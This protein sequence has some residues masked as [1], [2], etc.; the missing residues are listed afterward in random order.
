MEQETFDT[1][2]RDVLLKGTSCAILPSKKRVIFPLY[3]TPSLIL[4]HEEF[5]YLKKT[6]ILAANINSKIVGLNSTITVKEFSISPILKSDA[7][8]VNI[9][10][11]SLLFLL[12][13]AVDNIIKEKH[14]FTVEYQ[15]GFGV[16][17]SVS[18]V[19]LN[20]DLVEKISIEMG[21]L[22]DRDL[23]IYKEFLSHAQA[24]H[25]FVNNNREYSVAIIKSRN[26]EEVRVSSCQSHMDLYYTTLVP[27]TGILVKTFKLVFS[28]GG[29]YLTWPSDWNK[30]HQ[31]FGTTALAEMYEEMN[32]LGRKLGSS[33]TGQI[34]H[35]ILQNKGRKM[36][37]FIG[38]CA[39]RFNQKI[40]NVFDK[41]SSKREKN[42][43]LQLILIAGPSSSGK[44]TFA[45]T[46]CL[47]LET[48]GL[49]PV[50]ISVDD[51]YKP[52]DECPVDEFGNKDYEDIDA[53]RIDLLNKNL[54]D[55]MDGKEIESPIFDFI[56]GLPK[57]TGIKLRMEKDS[58]LVLEGIHCLNEE[59]AKTVPNENKFR[60]FLSAFSQLNIDEKQYVSNST[61]RL[62]RRLVR[63][64]K[65]RG[66]S[67]S[68][69]LKMW[70]NVRKA[71]HNF[72]FPHMDKSDVIFN[73][74]LDYEFNV[75]KVFVVPLLKGVEVEDPSY[76]KAR[77]LLN[78]LDQF[79]T[80]PDEFIPRESLLREFIG[81]S[82]FE[83]E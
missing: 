45:K 72:I 70:N 21:R 78:W 2:Q 38:L 25:Y 56:T 52:R 66:K 22:I 49:S 24:L 46:L 80:M 67:A 31:H 13:M 30:Y 79:E 61:N 64:Y 12:G 27:S 82:F 41:F 15:F 29:L 74:S 37:H 28:R 11:N 76:Y 53:L 33:C 32:T 51:Y 9:L 54:K 81:N 71:E 47:Q 73:S 63:D 75:L 34:N 14:L 23:P 4:E 55:L 7:E 65:Y 20:E 18:D 44:T 10:T 19:D 1:L 57:E 59:L 3:S 58:I 17:C 69:T 8:G 6:E 16:Q 83:D 5:N 77:Y 48:A 42:P 36:K 60:I 50:V 62:C 68:D 40:T 26:D 39:T 43:S 35:F